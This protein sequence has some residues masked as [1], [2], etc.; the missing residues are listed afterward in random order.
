MPDGR[1]VERIALA[2]GDLSAQV[3]TYG[4]IVQDIHLAPVGHSLILGF[5]DIGAY[6][7]DDAHIG[8]V[9]GRV[10]N[11]IAQGR[12]EIDGQLYPLDC[13]QGGRH[14]LHGGAEGA[15]RQ[16][17]RIEDAGP[18]HV[19]LAL[20]LPDGHMG[21]PGAVDL[22][23]RYEILDGGVFEITLDSRPAK[24][25]VCNLAPHLYFN[26]DGGGDAREHILRIPAE[27]VLPT[28]DEGIPTGEVLPVDKTPWDFRMAKTVG[29][30]GIRYDHNFCLSETRRP[31][32]MAAHLRGGGFGISMVLETT[33][34]G[35]QVYDGVGLS[36]PYSGLALE[37][38]GWPDA[39]NHARFPSILVP[40][41]ETLRQ[42]TRMTFST[43]RRSSDRRA[44]H[45]AK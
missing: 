25:G 5:E 21:F 44:Y 45:G 37:P 9:V 28:S 7:R 8:A 22:G 38:Q 33:E 34:P 10:A 29:E 36:E 40:P 15:S 26:L 31:L 39:P 14:T 3:L 24:R 32:S 17:W 11:R 30:G 18:R 4:A 43:G 16:L 19:A 27:H 42:A 13:N 23:A 41:G 6:I 1:P 2:G 20:H 35:L 12:M